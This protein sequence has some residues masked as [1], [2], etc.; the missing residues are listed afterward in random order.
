MAKAKQQA[1]LKEREAE[2]KVKAAFEALV[3]DHVSK[4]YQIDFR[5]LLVEGVPVQAQLK[6]LQSAKRKI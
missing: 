1:A 2:I 5:Q 3:H 4:G 6:I